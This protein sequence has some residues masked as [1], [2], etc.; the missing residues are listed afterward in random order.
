M[1]QKNRSV[2]R[3][4]TKYYVLRDTVIGFI[5]SLDKAFIVKKGVNRLPSHIVS[6]ERPMF[7]E[8]YKHKKRIKRVLVLT[9][10]CN[11]RCSYC[12]EGQHPAHQMMSAHQT[13]RIIEEMFREAEICGKKLI[14]FSL[15]GGEPTM[16]WEALLCAVKTSEKLENATG[17]RCYKA[18]VTNGVMHSNQAD[19][20]AEHM[21]FIYF[22]MDGPKELFLQ[23]RKPSNGENVYDVIFKNACKIYR[24]STYLSFKITITSKTVDHLKEID[25]FFAINFPTCGRLYQPC[26]VNKTDKLYV[27]FG[28]FL[29]KYLELKRYSLFSKNMTTPLF[30]NQPSDRFCNL[31]VRNVVYPDGVVLACHRSSMC[32]PDDEVKKEFYIGHCEDGTVHRELSL[33]YKLDKFTIN[34]IADCQCCPMKYHCCGGC[35][36]VKLLSN[37]HDMF[38]KADYCEDFLKFSFTIILS[39][40]FKSD[41]S[42][43]S[44]LPEHLEVDDFEMTQDDFIHNIVKKY[45]SIEEE[46]HHVK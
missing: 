9:D 27:S 17:I 29:E 34:N 33:Q 14:S 46:Y 45:I 25:D 7:H 35:A 43:L 4:E 42:Y 31:M 26:M 12:F 21:D 16:N 40:L 36:T 30:K 23:Q 8:S 32:I 38:R 24:S 37:N 1:N 5:P 11:L 13:Q 10:A 6:S 44:V 19:F 15:F 39:R 2:F 18:I 41:L 28:Y 20:L 3:H 22:S